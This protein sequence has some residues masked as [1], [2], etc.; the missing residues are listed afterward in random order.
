LYALED[1]YYA[2]YF[3]GIS[4]W[5]GWSCEDFGESRALT[6]EFAEVFERIIS[7]RDVAAMYG[8]T[9]RG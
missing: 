4:G 5:W 7:T 6:R 9:A 8:H 1:N 3:E 2:K